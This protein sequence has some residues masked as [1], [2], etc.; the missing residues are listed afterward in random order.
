MRL[1]EYCSNKIWF[2]L[3]TFLAVLFNGDLSTIHAQTWVITGNVTDAAGGPIPA[4]DIDLV[5]PLN[6]A[7]PILL[8]G[9]STDLNGNFSATIQS[10]IAIGEYLLQFEPTSAH[11][12]KEITISLNGNLDIGTVALATGWLLSGQVLNS[13]GL[14]M[15]GIDIDIRSDQ[16]GWLDLVGDVT[17]PQ[18]FFSVAI[19]AIIDEYR[20]TFSDTALNPTVF[21][22]EIDLGLLF[23]NTNT[24]VVT[25]DM[26]H[27]LTGLVIDENGVPLPGID[28][29]AY[30]LSGAPLDLFNDDTNASGIFNVLVPQGTWRFAIVWSLR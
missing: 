13:D 27:T 21:P 25:M 20:I 26:A 12:S 29:N 22:A 19:P 23:G 5:D 3:F 8:S 18:G 17:N 15:S 9:D 10:S 1:K 7:F 6:P 28:M 24:G 16:S 30:D 11:L 2:C 4:V 14:A